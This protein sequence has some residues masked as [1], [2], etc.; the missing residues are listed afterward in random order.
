VTRLVAQGLPVTVDEVFDLADYP[1]ALERL[2]QG[3]QLG[4]IVLRHPRR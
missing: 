1:A 4:K 2:R 3:A